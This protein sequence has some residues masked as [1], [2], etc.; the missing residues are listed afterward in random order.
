MQWFD[1]ELRFDINAPHLSEGFP[2]VIER[3][4]EVK[5][6]IHNVRSELL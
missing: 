5:G 1:L 4:T 3:V 2:V 6:C